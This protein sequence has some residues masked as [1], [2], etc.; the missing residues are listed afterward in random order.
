MPLTLPFP[1]APLSGEALRIEPIKDQHFLFVDTIKANRAR[2]N[3]DTIWA[4]KNT[5]KYD[6]VWCPADGN[7]GRWICIFAINIYDWKDLGRTPFQPAR[8]CYGF[9]N[10]ADF[11]KPA[12]ATTGTTSKIITPNSD[13]YD[14]FAP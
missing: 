12:N 11:S 10:L 4:N 3:L 2:Q 9:Y 1:S 14:P 5:L 13:R 7:D 8:G 6:C